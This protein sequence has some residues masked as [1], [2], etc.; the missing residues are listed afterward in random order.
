MTITMSR[1]LASLEAIKLYAMSINLPESEAERAY[2]YWESQ[3]WRVGRNPMRSWEAALRN[4]AR[5]YRDR[6]GNHGPRIAAYVQQPE[7]DWARE[8]RLKAELEVLRAKLFKIG[9]VSPI[10]SH[11]QAAQIRAAREPV[12]ARIRQ[13]KQE[14]GLL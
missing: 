13:V 1:P 2:D 5:N 3:G 14:L 12:L 6:L 8:K 10:H 11:E 4:W 7:P 9:D